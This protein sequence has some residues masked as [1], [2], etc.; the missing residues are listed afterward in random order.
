VLLGVCTHLGCSPKYRPEVG[1]PD[2]G[3]DW[4]G[5]FQCPCHGGRYDLAGRAYKGYPP[6][7]NLA[8][9]PHKY[10]SDTRLLI[11]ED[12]ETA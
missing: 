5:G 10:L 2:L 1:A 3:A 7:L 4:E 6:P 8:V 12:K 11:G 9:P